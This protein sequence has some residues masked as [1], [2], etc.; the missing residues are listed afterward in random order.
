M[1]RV[2]LHPG[3]VSTE[4]LKDLHVAKMPKAAAPAA[5]DA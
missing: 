2:P 1:Q 5:A 3:D 4:Q